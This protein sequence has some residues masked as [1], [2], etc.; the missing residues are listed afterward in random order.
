M[1]SGITE[2]M[3]QDKDQ[4]RVA[5]HV[6]SMPHGPR[7]G[8]RFPNGRVL[9][10]TALLV[11]LGGLLA[12]LY[13]PSRGETA[14]ENARSLPEA[15]SG[16]SLSPVEAV[17]VTLQDF[18]LRAE[19]TGYLTPW[20]STDIGSQANGLVAERLVEEGAFVRVGALLLQLDDRQQRI[21]LARAEADLLKIRA[22]YLVRMKNIADAELSDT[23][24]LAQAETMLREAEKSHERGVISETDLHEAQQRFEAAE[25]LS[26]SM[27]GT[28]S[29]AVHGLSQAQQRVE[30][31]RLA[32]DRTRVR[33]P[34]S[35]RVADIEV[36]V[37]Q[38]IG[39]GQTVLRV[40]DDARMKVEADVLEAD[41]VRLTAG[42]SVQ[43]RIPAFDNAIFEGAIYTINPSINPE[44]GTGRVTITLPNPGRKL[45][46]GLF[47]YVEL[48][49]DR[50]PERLTVPT[51]AVLV[52][53]G[54]DLIFRI[55]GGIA[56]W[57]YVTTGPASGNY[58]E[59]VEGLQPG[60]VVAV[61]GHY[62]LAHDTPVEIT[63]MH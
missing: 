36:E 11:A 24:D 44:T 15:R 19:A 43:A 17:T 28:V 31:A 2:T 7:P 38:H 32:L 39:A 46:T 26:G 61:A 55:E 9:V 21:E 59:I 35:G 16:T 33:A 42:A 4:R 51:N 1:H 34:F 60:D 54:R 49:S 50:L 58:V 30:Q 10:S 29:A 62:T 45:V 20:R 53:Q 8:R 41:L 18:V 40:L 13:W 5:E 56:K 37:G 47:A 6:A 57:I 25:V 63:A 14:G 12:Y 48:E 3:R 27:R 52:R 23:V 22:E